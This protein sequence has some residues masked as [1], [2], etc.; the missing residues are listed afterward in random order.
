MGQILNQIYLHLNNVYNFSLF[1]I[2]N[3]FPKQNI[4]RSINQSE[5]LRQVSHNLVTLSHSSAR[6][7]KQLTGF[8]FY[9]ISMQ[10]NQISLPGAF[11]QQWI[12]NQGLRTST[13]PNTCTISHT[14]HISS[15]LQRLHS[16]PQTTIENFPEVKVHQ[17]TLRLFISKCGLCVSLSRLFILYYV[18]GT[19]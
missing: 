14:G 18:N 6:C 17:P 12:S 11:I 15:A 2:Q 8:S 3:H 7:S 5:H 13:S 10:L 16:I 4:A 19:L 1:I 9:L